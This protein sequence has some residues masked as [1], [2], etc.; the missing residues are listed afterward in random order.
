MLAVWRLNIV[1][2]VVTSATYNI[3][4]LVGLTSRTFHTM[5]DFSVY[6]TT[7]DILLGSLAVERNLEQ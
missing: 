4:K 3:E 7:I 6:A 5:R 2:E 1:Y